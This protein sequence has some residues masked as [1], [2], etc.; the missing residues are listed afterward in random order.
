MKVAKILIANGADLTITNDKGN[1]PLQEVEAKMTS[2]PNVTGNAKD[3]A[4]ELISLLK[5][6]LKSQQKK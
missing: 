1:T 2:Q 4:N 5:K 3:H 6:T